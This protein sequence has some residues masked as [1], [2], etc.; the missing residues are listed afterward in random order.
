MR[1]QVLKIDCLTTNLEPWRPLMITDFDDFCTWMFVLVDDCG[2]V[3]RRCTAAQALIRPR[4]A[5]A[6]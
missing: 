6:R 2:K 1:L 3:L 5:I 4:V